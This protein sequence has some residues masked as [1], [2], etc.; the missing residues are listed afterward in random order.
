M[1]G[2]EKITKEKEGI[3]KRKEPKYDWGDVKSRL[4]NML[5]IIKWSIQLIT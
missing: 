5:Q 4:I 2:E 3:R 1:W